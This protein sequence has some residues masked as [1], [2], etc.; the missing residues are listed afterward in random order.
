VGFASRQYALTTE[1]A[2][3]ASAAA[4]GHRLAA[5]IT[6]LAVLSIAAAWAARRVSG[7]V[8][9]PRRVRLALDVGLVA[10]VAVL[11][12]AVLVAAGGPV[13]GAR[14]LKRQFEAPAGVTGDLNARIL[15]FSGN[16][17]SE[18]ITVAIDAGRER[19]LL[20]LGAGSYE[21]QWYEHRDSPYVIRD[22]HSLYA[23]MFGEVGFVGLG[24]LLAALAL[25]LVAAIR[26]RRS[27]TVPAAGAAFLA[28]AAHCTLDWNWELPG[29]TLTAL[30][31]GAAVLL[32]AERPRRAGTPLG[33][34]RVPLVALM[35]AL[36][37]ASVV[38]LVGNQAL[39]AGRAS[40]AE[41]RWADALGHARKA[42]ALV[43]WSHEPYVVYGDAAAGLGDRSAALDAYRTASER[44]PD[45]WLVW[46]RI[47]LV[48]RGNE[49]L[50]AYRRVH[51]LNPLE[52][53]LPERVY[54]EPSG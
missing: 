47:A 42:R 51:Q 7:R 22:A 12:A 38:S 21:A 34:V 23:E 10:G 31:A 39:F 44:A 8:P 43:P 15:S 18:Q 29:V 54:R 52:Q 45:N 2:P 4:E 27:R 19:T 13:D 28:W 3:A 25:P 1:D 16:G 32:A 11:G 6:V 35:C 20:G 5:A 49:R 14:S 41:E 37:F 30:L 40:I 50:A 46:S 17:R 53:G 24:L 36:T 48:A 9:V 26:A 33:A